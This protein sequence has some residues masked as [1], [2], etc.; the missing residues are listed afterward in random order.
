[1]DHIINWALRGAFVLV[2]L[3][4]GVW[5]FRWLVHAWRHA[6]ERWPL[7]I[8]IGMLLLGRIPVEGSYVADL[9]PGFFLFA[10]G[11]GLTFVTAIVAAT[12]GVTDSEQG[13][14]SGLINTSQQVGTALGLAILVTVAAARTDALAGSV[15]PPAVLVEGYRYGFT[16]GA[17]LAGLGVLVA[18]F[19][20]RER[21]CAEEV[22]RPGPEPARVPCPPV[23]TLAVKYRARRPRHSH[24]AKE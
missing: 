10:L 19:F 11:L 6:E 1:M 7:R 3:G 9:L 17:G 8:A 23:T 15:G 16:A 22:S 20:V 18:F 5:I 24:S 21:E 14:A 2:G 12:A 4:A 13:L